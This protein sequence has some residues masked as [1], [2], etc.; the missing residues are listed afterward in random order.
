MADTDSSVPSSF[1]CPA[2]YVKPEREFPASRHVLPP[3]PPEVTAEFSLLAQEAVI[4]M[5]RDTSNPLRGVDDWMDR[6]QAEGDFTEGSME[7]L[8]DA[9][10]GH[11][12]KM[13]VYE[14][15]IGRD[16]HA[17]R[18]GALAAQFAD[19]LSRSF[20]PDSKSTNVG[21]SVT[22]PFPPDLLLQEGSSRYRDSKSKRPEGDREQTRTTRRSKTTGCYP[23]RHR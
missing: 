22:N 12:R 14:L 8:L 11:L 7:Q 3:A 21:E 9:S 1:E 6:L 10:R 16:D 4:L 5:A 13:R 17:E 19:L 23:R 18:C 20:G 15:G 2:P